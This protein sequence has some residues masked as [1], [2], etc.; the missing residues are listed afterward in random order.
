MD[1]FVGRA[2]VFDAL[3]RWLAAPAGG[4]W[5]LLQGGP[6]SG[7]TAIAN[8]LVQFSEGVVAADS[9]PLLGTRA[10]ACSHFC[11]AGNDITLNPL[12]FVEALSTALAQR[13]APFAAALLNLQQRE[14]RITITQTVGMVAAGGVVYGVNQVIIADLS[15]RHAFD[16]AVR[17]PLEQLCAPGFAETILLLVD[18]LDEALTYRGETIAELIHETTDDPAELPAQVR[19]IL[20]SRPEVEIAN[21]FGAP[22]LDLNADQPPGVDDVLE[23]ALHRLAPLSEPRKTRLATR[24]AEKQSGNFLYAR[25]VIDGLL[26]RAGEIEEGRRIRLPNTLESVY[27]KFLERKLARRAEHWRETYRPLLGVLAVA[28]GAGLTREQIVEIVGRRYGIEQSTIDDALDDCREYLIGGTNGSLQIYHRSFRDF[29]TEDNTYHIYPAEANRA[30]GDYFVERYGDD[31]AHCTDLHA[32]Q[33][34]T[35]YLAAGLEGLRAGQ[36]QTRA[37]VLHELMQNASYLEAASERLDRPDAVLDGFRTAVRVALDDDELSWAWRHVS[38]F[39]DVARSQRSSQRIFALADVQAY[40]AAL[41]LAALHGAKPRSQALLRLWIAWQAARTDP[42]RAHDIARQALELLPLELL[43]AADEPAPLPGGVWVAAAGW[44]LARIARRAG[45]TLAA[46]RAWLADVIRNLPAHV[47]HTIAGQLKQPPSA[48]ALLF[49]PA[50]AASPDELIAMMEERVKQQQV[51]GEESFHFRRGLA[52]VVAQTREDPDWHWKYVVR[53]V[54]LVA[55]DDYPSYR[56]MALGWL[57]AAALTNDQDEQ[58]DRALRTILETSIDQVEL[59][60]AGNLAAVTLVQ[61]A[62]LQSRTL[63]SAELLQ[64]LRSVVLPSVA[65]RGLSWLDPGI[66]L[67]RSDPWALEIRLRV[68]AAIALHSQ[69]RDAD[70]AQLLYEA[71]KLPYQETYAGYR[72]PAC[73]SVACMFVALGDATGAAMAITEAR[74]SAQAMLDGVLSAERLALVDAMQAWLDTTGN[75]SQADIDNELRRIPALS[76]A[77]RGLRLEYLAARHAGDQDALHRLALAAISDLTVADTILAWLARLAAQR[78]DLRGAR[79]DN[80]AQETGRNP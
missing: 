30:I 63:T 80:L 5:F 64:E 67:V 46:Q 57:A 17:R 61:H 71:L 23:Y 4:R 40:D 16:L 7:K 50:Y 35:A 43:V 3:T 70:A 60:F 12:R 56:E 66:G 79:L 14:P 27:R 8:R 65:S 58:A 20:T 68:A 6:G 10:L 22:T 36:R 21:W 77:A 19:L 59:A 13:Y 18:S 39:N 11:R 52:W 1:D 9:W 48:W 75:H 26:E 32:L 73:L 2:W 45:A 44:L 29:L 15:A 33:Y 31:W 74:A 69:N 42:M 28:N 72:A 47:R 53:A 49:L 76:D 25:H 24:L 34:T 37:H 55:L 51:H 54:A 62:A 38:R 41:S 78:G